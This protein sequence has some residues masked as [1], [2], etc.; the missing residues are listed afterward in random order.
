MSNFVS[1][2]DAP[3]YRSAISG[4]WY[5]NLKAAGDIDAVELRSQRLVRHADEKLFSWV[6]RLVDW[7]ET[8]QNGPQE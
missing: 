2:E 5:E 7:L 3:L 1:K 8:M 4:M 6:H